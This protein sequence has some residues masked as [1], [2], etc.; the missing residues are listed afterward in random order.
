MLHHRLLA[1][2]AVAALGFAGAQAASAQS[3]PLDTRPGLS[4]VQATIGGA[5]TESIEDV[6]IRTERELARAEDEA[7]FGTAGVPEGFRGSVFATGVWETG[8]ND[9]VD[10]GVGGR[11]T[12]GQAPISHTLGFG[13]EYGS[14]D[15]VRDRNRVLGIY[16]LN[17]NFTDQFY[18]FGLARGVYDEFASTNEVD[19]FAGVGPGWRVIAQP[20]LAW[21]VQAGPGVRYTKDV[22]TGDTETELAGIASSRFYWQASQDVFFTNDTDVLYSDAAE[23][24]VSNEAALNTRLAG[25]LSARV[26]LRTDWSSDPSV[27][28]GVQRDSTDNRLSFGI[29]YTLQ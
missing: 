15:D 19:A 18:A 10:L 11:F 28:N 22:V 17:Y 24:Q 3:R 7:R 16:D 20:D 29:V 5:T 26:G 6:Q 14:S 12:L 13:V 8:N 2:A 25:P 1:G 4:P 9:N 21:R 27:E 23:W